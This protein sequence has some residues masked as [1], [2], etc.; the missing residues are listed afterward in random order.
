M[1]NFVQ[2]IIQMYV[3]QIH[4]QYFYGKIWRPKITKNNEKGT[5]KIIQPKFKQKYWQWKLWKTYQIVATQQA[6][7]CSKLTIKTLK[8]GV[9]CVQN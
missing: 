8:K 7:T 5:G 4:I 1:E 3:K 6:F 9:D 2:F